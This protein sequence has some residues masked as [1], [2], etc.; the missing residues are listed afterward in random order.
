MNRDL[1][2]GK[3]QFVY[4]QLFFKP[5]GGLCDDMDIYVRVL[6]VKLSDE[7]RHEEYAT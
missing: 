7:P 2:D 3:V 4:K 6:N 1:T 5:Q